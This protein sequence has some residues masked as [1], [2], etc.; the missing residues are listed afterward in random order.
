MTGESENVRG[1]VK[2]EMRWKTTTASHSTLACLLLVTRTV[3]SESVTV[4][5][6]STQSVDDNGQALCSCPQ[7]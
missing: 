4:K 3:H 7:Y 5:S 1:L 6:F 2:R